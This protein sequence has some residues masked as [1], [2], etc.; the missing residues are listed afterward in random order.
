MVATRISVA[1][2]EAVRGDDRF[3]LIDGKIVRMPL[4]DAGSSSIAQWIGYLLGRHVFLLALGDLY[5]ADGGFVLFPDRETVRIPDVA[6]VRADRAPQGEALDHFVRVP[7]DLAVEVMSAFDRAGEIAAKVVMYQEAGVP[8]VWLVDRW[9]KRVAVFALG[10]EPV[11]LG[12]GD[13]LTGGDVLPE[14]RV[15]VAEVFA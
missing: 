12:I 13:E 1:E 15:A 11:T 8:L 14:F 9:A 3:E 7:P 6:F 4:S 10:Q 2:F 5:S